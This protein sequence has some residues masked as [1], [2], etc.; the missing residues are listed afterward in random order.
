MQDVEKNPMVAV[1]DDEIDL[2][3]LVLVLWKKRYLILLVTI[4]I[5]VLTVS[6]SL[7]LPNIY[8]AE[9][10]FLLPQQSDSKMAGMMSQLSQ[11]PFL[12]GN[13]SGGNDGGDSF[14][15]L[16]AHLQKKENL[17]KVI[18]AFDLKK[19]YE[20][21]SEFR[22]DMEKAYLKNVSLEK[23]KQ[24]GIVSIFV[25]DQDPKLAKEI[26]EMNLKLLEEISLNTAV[27]ETRRK[28]EFLEK[29]LSQ[30]KLEL[31]DVEEVIRKYMIENKL[32]SL[33]SQADATISAASKVQ[34]EILLNQIKLKV[35]LKMGVN[36]NHPDIRLLRLENQAMEKQLS[37]I[38]NG[39]MIL[40]GETT[41][42]NKGALTY[43]S[44]QNLPSLQLELARLKREH[45]IKQEI[46]KV[47]TKEYELAKMDS[48]KEQEYVEVIEH[49]TIP[50]K[51]DKPR[52]SI[53]C[54]VGTLSGFLLACFAVLL[55]N[56]FV[57]QREKI[58]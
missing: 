12:A 46:F 40:D 58:A 5:A 2:L 18:N 57:S 16:K 39:E 19:H 42:V 53:I 22:I 1:Q 27:T 8:K 32:L 36:E 33:E 56:A 54:I 25:W 41:E 43:V 24:S 49:A 44:L 23:D 52:R 47:L 11:I 9:V 30:V 3:A 15:I 55:H 31:T 45:T 20:L 13:L 14:E 7:F 37:R 26:A 48:A 4:A 28:R 51:K 35:K 34:S 6:Y 17:W 10:K 21:T 38:E 50:E 29:R